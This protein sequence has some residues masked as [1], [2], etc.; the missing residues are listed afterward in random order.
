MSITF[1]RG[2]QKH[3]GGG[4]PAPLTWDYATRFFKPGGGSW[5]GCGQDLAL[6]TCSNGHTLRMSATV[7]SIAPDGEVT[8]SYVCTVEGC[9]FH[10]WV[11]FEG[12]DPGHIFESKVI[13]E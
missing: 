1:T 13:G 5:A 10:R 11:R 8:P 4:Q 7:H 9:S 2:S 6:C 3:A 12:W